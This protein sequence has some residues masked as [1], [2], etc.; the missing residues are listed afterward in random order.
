M[1][2]TFK[3]NGYLPLE[4]SFGSLKEHQCQKRKNIHNK[5]M[6]SNNYFNYCVSELEHSNVNMTAHFKNKIEIFVPRTPNKIGNCLNTTTTINDVFYNLL[7]N[8]SIGMDSTSPSYRDEFIN[9]SEFEKLELAN[10]YNI[11]DGRQENYKL[12]KDINKMK[13]QL[14]RRNKIGYFKGHDKTN[15]NTEYWNEMNE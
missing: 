1:G 14:K 2:K 6:L 7:F 8:Y 12:A 11:M 10:Q 4:H 3:S 5:K 13:I 15:N 9:M